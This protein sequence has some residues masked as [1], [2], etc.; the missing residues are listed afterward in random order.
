MQ[1]RKGFFLRLVL[2]IVT[3]FFVTFFLTGC[4]EGG[5]G[6]GITPTNPGTTNPVHTEFSGSKPYIHE[7]GKSYTAAVSVRET[8]GDDIVINRTRTY[9][10]FTMGAN[11]DTEQSGNYY[12]AGAS[13]VYGYMLVPNSNAY[14][15]NISSLGSVNQHLLKGYETRTIRTSV[16]IGRQNESK[17]AAFNGIFIGFSEYKSWVDAGKTGIKYWIVLEGYDYKLNDNYNI[18]MPLEINFSNSMA[19]SNPGTVTNPGNTNPHDD[20][21]YTNPFQQSQR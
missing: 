15:E 9:R 12:N 3:A 16:M 13:L 14:V 20:D 1:T 6:G 19:A 10:T 8:R 18:Y 11:Y 17:P 2:S 4:P 7:L 5:G 21:G